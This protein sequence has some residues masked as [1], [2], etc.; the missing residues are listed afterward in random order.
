MGTGS[1]IIRCIHGD[2]SNQTVHRPGGKERKPR[3]VRR[4]EKVL[5]TPVQESVTSPPIEGDI[6]DICRF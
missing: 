4:R 5:G 1:V 6:V 2:E 3:S